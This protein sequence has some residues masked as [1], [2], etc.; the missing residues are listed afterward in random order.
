MR[1]YYHLFRSPLRRLRSNSQ[2]FMLILH[3][4]TSLL[5][6]LLP[7]YYS[8]V[9]L[10]NMD[11]QLRTARKLGVSWTLG[12]TGRQWVTVGDSGRRVSAQ[13]QFSRVL[14]TD[15]AANL[16]HNYCGRGRNKCGYWSYCSV[17]QDITRWYLWLGIIVIKP[18]FFEQFRCQIS[19]SFL[20]LFLYEVCEIL[21]SV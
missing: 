19:W 17:V 14:S 20:M 8:D 13:R 21:F 11:V 18:I 2:F 5:T 4:F 7:I 16:R 1:S 6:L 9:V 3:L 12:D 15:A 10:W